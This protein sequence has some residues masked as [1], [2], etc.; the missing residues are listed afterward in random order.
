MS[1][2]STETLRRASVASL[3]PV[4]FAFFGLGNGDAGVLWPVFTPAVA[5]YFGGMGI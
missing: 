3:L 5:T 2:D 1:A 4:F